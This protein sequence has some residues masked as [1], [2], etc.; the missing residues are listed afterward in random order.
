[1]AFS[2]TLWRR[3]RGITTARGHGRVSSLVV[4]GRLVGRSR[5]HGNLHAALLQV[6]F[7]N[8]M[9]LHQGEK[10]PEILKA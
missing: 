10:L 4:N 2:M 5:G 1:M 7:R 3:S 6:Q 9:G 8:F